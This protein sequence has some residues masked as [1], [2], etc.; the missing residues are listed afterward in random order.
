MS[1]EAKESKI[2]ILVAFEGLIGGKSEE[3][4]PLAIQFL[5]TSDKSS[6]E[7]AYDWDFDDSSH[8]I[9]VFKK[10]ENVTPLTYRNAVAS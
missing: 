1:T 8:F 7:V 2:S 5:K 4:F 9:K 10:H 3:G 6:Y